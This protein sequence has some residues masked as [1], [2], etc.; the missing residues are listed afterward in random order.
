MR[1]K[2]I[3]AIFKCINYFRPKPQIKQI[4]DKINLLTQNWFK[5]VLYTDY[6]S[7]TPT[8]VYDKCNTKYKSK[9][10]FLNK[11]DVEKA[12]GKVFK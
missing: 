9:K 5:D 12:I 7:D 3:N 4:E 11:N 1:K 8:L 2:L 10:I 6:K